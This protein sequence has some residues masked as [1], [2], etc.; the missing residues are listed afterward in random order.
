MAGYLLTSFLIAPS[1]TH[2][3]GWQYPGDIWMNLQL[4][5]NVG[6]GDYANI[7][8]Q[9]SLVASPAILLVLL[10]LELVI[11]HFGL[12]TGFGFAGLRPTA[13]PLVA[14]AMVLLSA[15]A[16][17][18][19]DSL[20]EL[21]GTQ[22]RHRMAIGICGAIAL[23]NVLWWGHPEDALS[24]AFL[25]FAIRGAVGGRWVL[26]AW[27]LGAGFA[28]Q[29]LIG[30][31]IPVVILSAGWRRVPT[32]VLRVLAPAAALLVVPFASD[33]ADT[34]RAEILQPVFPNLVRPTAWLRFAPHISN[35]TFLG[36]RSVAGGPMRLVPIAIA[37]AIGVW[38]TR[39]ERSPEL[40]IWCVATI[41]ALR[42]LTEAAVAPYYVW[43]P[44]A[45]ALVSASLGSWK[46]VL[47]TGFCVVGVTWLANVRVHTEWLWW[48]ISAGLVLCLIVSFPA[49]LRGHGLAEST[50]CVPVGESD[51]VGAGPQLVPSSGRR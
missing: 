21:I 14:P 26:C 31:A 22:W 33:W 15:P 2:S 27:L 49:R 17:F 47:M 28:F 43:P 1:L 9:A 46:R 3:P 8:Y 20:A 11:Q 18:A 10:P 6:L 29:P 36:G 25:L 50:P 12:T 24:V 23:E 44:L 16:L 39:R 5:N 7:Y 37:V 32:L 40:L 51:D 45:V 42:Y 34:Y 30:L 38:F 48:P 4:A 13:W 41:L 35:E 19:A